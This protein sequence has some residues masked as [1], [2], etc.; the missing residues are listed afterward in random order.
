MRLGGREEQARA[1]LADGGILGMSTRHLSLGFAALV[2]LTTVVVGVLGFASVEITEHALNYSL[3]RRKVEQRTYPPGRYW[4]SP[5]NFFIKFPATVTTIQF[6]DSAMQDD[7][8]STER[9]ESQLRSRTRDGLD[10]L[11]ELSFQYQLVGDSIYDLYTLLGGYP[12][13]HD[14]F[15]RI[16]VDRLTETA[17]KYSA[18]EFFTQRT[19]IGRDMEALL[20]R[21]F[22]SDLFA[23]VF[24]FQLRSVGLP[25][26]FEEA[27][28]QT[29]VMKQDLSVAVAEQNS[30]R[31]SLETQLMQARRGTRVA[32]NRGEAEAAAVMLANAAEIAQYNATQR[33]AADGY[34]GVLEAL[35]SEQGALLEYMRARALRDHPSQRTVVG[36]DVPPPSKV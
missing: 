32:A 24:S 2:A 12:D 5:L 16:A 8:S 35:G 20:E 7:L 25:K 11:I 23:H 27:I 17:T 30:T 29:E 31:V 10:V 9:G 22:A 13:Y 28:Q 36:L 34:S 33:R 26:E 18:T 14:T 6:S 15:V 3:V 19:A 21:D 1:P 4:I